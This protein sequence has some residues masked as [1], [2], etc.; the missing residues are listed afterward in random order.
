MKHPILTGAAAAIAFT[1][2]GA[3]TAAD[4]TFDVPVHL[5]NVPSMTA[6]AVECL[7]SRVAL[8]GPYA[9]GG[10]NV[11]GR[12]SASI[13]VS[14]GSY[15]GTVSVEVN[16]SSIIPSSEARSYICSMRAAGTARTGAT[17]AASTDNFGSVYEL[18]TGQTLERLVVRAE[19]GLP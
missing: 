5:E 8:G 3:A 17:Y 7:V 11:I 12:G 14:G 16:N 9:A 1:F 6:V 15:D 18:A 13:A 10:T 4:F 19:A 2:S